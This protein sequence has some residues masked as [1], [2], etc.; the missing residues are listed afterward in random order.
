MNEPNAT[1]SATI[2]LG[3]LRIQAKELLKAIRDGQA[4]AFARV[5]PYF[6]PQDEMS[7]VRAQLV[8]AR[9]RGFASWA[10]LR[11]AAGETDRADPVRLAFEAVEAR[12]ENRLTRLLRTSPDLA[13]AWRRTEWGWEGLLH[14]A[15]R[16]GFL[17]IARLL[18]D[19]GADVYPL[20]QGDYPPVFA[21][22]YG[23][24]VEVVEYLLAE[25]TA[26]DH[27]Q[28][29]TY[30]CGI[31]IVLAAR[32]GMLDRV[33]MHIQKD[34]FAVYRRG[35]IGETVLHWPAHNGDV[36]VVEALLTA[37]AAVGADEIGL[38]GGQPIHWAAEHEPAT[39]RLLL[40]HKADPMARNLMKN[41]FEGYTPLHMCARQPEQRVECAQILLDAGADIL[42]RDAKGQTPRDI[43]IQNGR[44]AMA[45]FLASRKP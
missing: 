22:H 11:R 7:L 23:G 19:S 10:D 40:M 35:C 14:V 44:S 20:R 28:P 9:E 3:Q 5:L 32:L 26:R 6:R 16:Q 29:P 36:A 17:E 13:G 31:D 18:V 38:Y 41:D 27:G 21:A 8:I 42:A 15:A 33:L 39:L 37:G 34:P 30:G 25:S 43:A 45:E 4:D 24:H 2:D 1:H 12:D